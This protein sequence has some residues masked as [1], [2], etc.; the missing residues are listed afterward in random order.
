[1]LL[2]RALLLI[3]AMLLT[4]GAKEQPLQ[5]EEHNWPPPCPSSCQPAALSFVVVN[6]GSRLLPACHHDYVLQP[7]SRSD[8]V[9]EHSL[10]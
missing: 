5:Q 10:G 3:C 8:E 1:M 2:H 9:E 4:H 7:A 6:S